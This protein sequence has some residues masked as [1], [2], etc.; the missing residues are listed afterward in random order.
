MLHKWSKD[1]YSKSYKYYVGEKAYDVIKVHN[2]RTCV[3]CGLKKGSA[4]GYF[5]YFSRLVYMDE[6]RILT[7]DKL[8]YG[9]INKE[10]MFFKE[11]EFEL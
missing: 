9:C 3:N 11:N 1:K 2:I 10:E 4:K 6:D 7:L 5:S 8:P